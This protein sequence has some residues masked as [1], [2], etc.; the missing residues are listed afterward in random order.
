[1]HRDEAVDAGT[2]RAAV[3]AVAEGEDAAGREHTR[4]GCEEALDRRGIRQVGERCRRGRARRPSA[5]RWPRERRQGRPR[6]RDRRGRGAQ[7]GEQAGVEVDRGDGLAGPC[8]RNRVDAEASAEAEV[9]REAGEIVT[10]EPGCC[11]VERIARAGDGSRVVL[12]EELVVVLLRAGHGRGIL[13]RGGEAMRVP[14][15]YLAF[16]GAPRQGRCPRCHPG[17]ARGGGSGCFL[18]N[19]GGGY[20]APESPRTDAEACQTRAR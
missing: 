5:S 16:R 9:A 1:V 17:D 20:V 8:Q 18:G 13:P 7:L 4:R 19:S 2:R 11:P 10:R 12:A 3:V 14:V 15:G 6:D